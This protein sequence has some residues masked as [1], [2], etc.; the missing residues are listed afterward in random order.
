MKELALLQQMYNECG[1]YNAL[2]KAKTYPDAVEDFYR[3]YNPIFREL[4]ENVAALAQNIEE[5]YAREKEEEKKERSV[6]K[7]AVFKGKESDE[8]ALNRPD[9]P[10]LSGDMKKVLFHV[11]DSFIE[12]SVNI[13]K[14]KGKLPKGRKSIELNMY[15]VM[16]VF[17]GII[18]TGSEFSWEI[19]ETIGERWHNSFES[20]V[21]KCTDYDTINAG[22][23]RSIFRFFR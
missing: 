20:N 9:R 21:L 11:A 2:F 16:Y 15:M 19:A 10:K 17:P 4:N 7:K 3:K 5:K 14:E 22:F 1:H 13:W 18:A 6:I 23:R 12:E 8:K